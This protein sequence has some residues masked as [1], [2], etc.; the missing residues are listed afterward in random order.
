MAWYG[1]KSAMEAVMRVSVPSGIGSGVS[2][3]QDVPIASKANLPAVV[4][5]GTRLVFDL[6]HGVI[7]P[8][9]GQR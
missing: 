4:I 3:C 9:G 6:L 2:I 8:T 7:E 1:N 5:S